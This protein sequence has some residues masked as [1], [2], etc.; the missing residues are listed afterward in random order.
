MRFSVLPIAILLIAATSQA[1][2]TWSDPDHDSL[3]PQGQHDI[4][5]LWAQDQQGDLALRLELYGAMTADGTA[6][7]LL[8]WQ[9]ET[10]Q[11]WLRCAATAAHEGPQLHCT[12]ERRTLEPTASWLTPEPVSE[13]TFDVLL[14]DGGATLFVQVHGAAAAGIPERLLAA[15]YVCPPILAASF[16]G[17]TL[18]ILSDSTAEPSPEHPLPLILRVNPADPTSLPP[19]LPDPGNDPEVPA[20]PEAGNDPEVPA[21][22]EAGN[23]PAPS[24]EV[25]G[26]EPPSDP[27][28]P[29]TPELPAVE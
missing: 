26:V 4:A 14:L 19:S 16:A 9:N 18:C 12:A 25:P 3:S 10:H 1:G 21:V 17:L 7:Y 11:S 5:H 20:V 23:D 22:P 8:A 28:A 29:A 15:A 2:T 13:Q 24:I 6:T 27:G